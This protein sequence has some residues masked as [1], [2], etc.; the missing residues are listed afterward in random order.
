MSGDPLVTHFTRQ[1]QRRREAVVYA[2][3]CD[4]WIWA[5]A[6][7]TLAFRLW[8]LDR[9][10]YQAIFE[11]KFWPC[12]FLLEGLLQLSVV[13]LAWVRLSKTTRNRDFWVF[14]AAAVF[15][16][17][18]NAII[19]A[20]WATVIFGQNQL[21]V[22]F[23]FFGVFLTIPAILFALYCALVTPSLVSLWIYAVTVTI[24]LKCAALIPVNRTSPLVFIAY[25]AIILIALLSVV[26]PLRFA[27][28]KTKPQM[29]DAVS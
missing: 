23:A 24:A 26:L 18:V 9:F 14:T 4:L 15:S 16:F 20:A 25:L 28:A 29:D 12:V 7:S 11:G 1:T 3:I 27:F 13:V 22:T 21:A 17:L 5:N 8:V 10:N 2:A 6:V 19:V